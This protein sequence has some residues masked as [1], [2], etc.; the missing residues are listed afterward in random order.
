MQA[1]LQ[2]LLV[3]GGVRGGVKGVAAVEIL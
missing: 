1:Q 3:V 2:V